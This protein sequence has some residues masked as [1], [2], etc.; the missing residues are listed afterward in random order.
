MYLQRIS[1]H[2]YQSN[3]KFQPKTVAFIL[4]SDHSFLQAWIA[5]TLYS[6]IVLNSRPILQKSISMS[7]LSTSVQVLTKNKP[8]YLKTDPGLMKIRGEIL[9]ATQRFEFENLKKLRENARA[10]SEAEEYRNIPHIFRASFGHFGTW[11]G[12][13]SHSIKFVF[14]KKYII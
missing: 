10:A 13:G 11:R 1:R 3:Y 14:S 7:T 8:Y 12:G 2:S 6:N 4:K 9:S 5:Q